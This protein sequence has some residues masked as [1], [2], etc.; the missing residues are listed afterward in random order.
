MRRLELIAEGGRPTPTRTLRE[1]HGSGSALS[2]CASNTKRALWAGRRVD[3]TL[4]EFKIVTMLAE[5][6]GQDIG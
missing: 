5:K 3:L 4:T 6:A 1:R 2:R